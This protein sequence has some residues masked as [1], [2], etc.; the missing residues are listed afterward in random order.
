MSLTVYR[1]HKSKC[2]H[3]DDR[4]SKSCRCALWV[5]GRIEGKPIKR[6]LKTRNWDRADQIKNSLEA[7]IQPVEKPA[8]VTVAHAIQKYYE[9]CEQRRLSENTLRKYRTVK[10]IISEFADQRVIVRL[11]DF[12]QQHVRDLIKQRKLGALTSAKEIERIRTFFTFCVDNDWLE[13]NPARPVK[14]PKVKQ[15]P[16]L[17][18]TEQ[19]IQNLIAQVKDD[20]ELAFILML[21]HTGLR[22]GDASLLR[23]TQCVDGRIYLYTTKAGTPVSV[24]IPPTLQSLL[25]AL[26]TPGGYFFLIGESTNPHTASNLWRR[27]IK[28]MCKDAKISPDHPHRFRHTLAA[29]S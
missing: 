9:A 24:V 15:L 19:E 26:P 4:I 21:R 14:P 12:T 29:D 28:R 1:R 16:R 3:K 20:R 11:A 8:A 6:S 23:A 27:R 18:F 5:V 2:K 10:K 13:K 17:P 7:N 22:I 25:K